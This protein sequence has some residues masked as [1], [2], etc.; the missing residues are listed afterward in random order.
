MSAQ[1]LVLEGATA[2]ETSGQYFQAGARGFIPPGQSQPQ[3]LVALQI[4]LGTRENCESRLAQI[5]KSKEAAEAF[6]SGALWCSSESA[7]VQLK[8]HGAFRNRVSGKSLVV[9]SQYIELCTS[10]VEALTGGQ[11]PNNKI[12]VTTACQAR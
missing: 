4:D 1:S 9:E 8:F 2:A 10:A 3:A 12:E 11:A 5:A 6:G 7:T